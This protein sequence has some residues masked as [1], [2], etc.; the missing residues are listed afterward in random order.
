MI[1]LVP[2]CRFNKLKPF[3]WPSGFLVD[4]VVVQSAV[5]D[6]GRKYLMLS[7]TKQLTSLTIYH[8]SPGFAD[9]RSISVYSASVAITQNILSKFNAAIAIG[10]Y[11]R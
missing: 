6:S 8:P 9:V 7:S 3:L 10:I 1:V 11:S 4:P 2:I 5:L